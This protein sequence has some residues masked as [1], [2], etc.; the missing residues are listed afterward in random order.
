MQKEAEIRPCAR[1]AG[2]GCPG[3]WGLL[4]CLPW[5]SR[6]A[7]RVFAQT[8]PVSLRII[9]VVLDK[10]TLAHWSPLVPSVSFD[11]FFSPRASLA[12]GFTHLFEIVT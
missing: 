8:P 11:V 4:H 12:Y 2:K 6:R 5:G 9:L 3:S 7:S 10:D 1:R